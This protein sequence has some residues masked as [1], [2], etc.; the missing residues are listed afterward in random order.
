MRIAFVTAGAA[1]MFCGSC[2]RDNT[3]AAALVEQGHDALLIPTFTPIR[4]DDEDVSGDRVFFG[5]INVYLR[6]KFRFFRHTPRLLDRVL[7]AP[8]LLRFASRFAGVSDYE[9]FADITVSML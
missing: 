2:M 1:G 7:N 5:G 9:Q 4:T 8:W 6:Q 3:L